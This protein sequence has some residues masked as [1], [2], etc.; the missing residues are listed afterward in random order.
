MSRFKKLAATL[1]ATSLLAVGAA[2]PAAAQNNSQQTGLV[3]VSLGDVALLNNVNLA[4]AA[5]VAA[6]V[7]DVTVP[8]AVLAR[9]F[10]ADT[11]TTVCETEAGDLVVEQALNGP[12][13]GSKPNA[14]G[15]NSQQEG[16]VNVSIGDID[17]L[18]NVNLAVAANV[19]ATVCDITVPVAILAIQAGFDSGDAICETTAG[20]L[21]VTQAQ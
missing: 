6:T 21:R 11:G 12:R 20:P 8:V 10:G 9:Q 19:A 17:I 4:V 5:N 7:C 14:G 2:G 18:N 1:F 15:N 3:N 16:L 13:K